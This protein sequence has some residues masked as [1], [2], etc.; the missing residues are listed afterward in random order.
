MNPKFLIL[1]L[2]AGTVA[3]ILVIYKAVTTYSDLNTGGILLNLIISVFFYYLAYKTY[4]EKKD[5]EL[6]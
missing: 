6:M 4:H 2:I 3:L 5:K 1:Y